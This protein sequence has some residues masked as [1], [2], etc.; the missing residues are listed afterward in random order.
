MGYLWKVTDSYTTLG[1]GAAV[2]LLGDWKD[3]NL[4]MIM[5]LRISS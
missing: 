5:F 4:L 1:L 3:K 2:L